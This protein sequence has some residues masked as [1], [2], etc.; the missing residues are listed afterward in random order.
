MNIVKLSDISDIRVSNVDKKSKTNQKVVKLCNYTDIYHN[1]DI[2]NDINFMIAT[3][4]DNE[5]EK[6]SIKK[7]QVAITKDSETAADIGM[8][9]YIKEDFKDVVLGYHLALFTPHENK[10]D[11]QYLNYY[12]HTQ[13]IRNWFENNA[14]GSGQRVSLSLNCLSSIPILMPKYATQL[15]IST[16]LGKLDEKIRMST[17]VNSKLEKI[18]KLIYDQWFVQFDFPDENNRPLLSCVSG[19]LRLGAQHV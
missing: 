13:S 10:L 7:G 8:S 15:H 2:T 12:I 14:G 16:L 9:A 11:G 4:S 19:L 17:K 3:A 6:F 5:I 1:T 18:A